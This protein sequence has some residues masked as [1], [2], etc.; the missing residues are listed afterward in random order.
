MDVLLHVGLDVDGRLHLPSP[1]IM[2]SVQHMRC[3]VCLCLCDHEASW[4]GPLHLQQQIL[5]WFMYV[6]QTNRG[7]KKESLPPPARRLIFVGRKEGRKERR[8]T[9]EG[10]TKKS[11]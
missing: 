2:H 6:R 3:C 4:Q 11:Y 10:Q 5:Q 1:S 7:K 8:K 9:V